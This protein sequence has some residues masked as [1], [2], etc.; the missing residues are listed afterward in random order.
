MSKVSAV[1]KRMRGMVKESDGKA[2]QDPVRSR[3]GRQ[4]REQAE[5]ERSALR[6]ARLRD[7]GESR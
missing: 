1:L 7:G 2:L 4:M 3:R 6:E 5:A